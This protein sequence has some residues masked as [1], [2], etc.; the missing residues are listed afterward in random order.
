MDPRLSQRGSAAKNPAFVSAALGIELGIFGLQGKC[1]SDKSHPSPKDHASQE[2]HLLL[3][4]KI[5][6]VACSANTR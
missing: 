6:H 2:G 1:S 5:S 4:M 3:T